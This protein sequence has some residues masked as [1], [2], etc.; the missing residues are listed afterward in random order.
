[1]RNLFKYHLL[2]GD[3]EIMAD[4]IKTGIS[5]FDDLIK[6]GLV[7][8]SINLVTGGPGSGK[9][10]FS[11]AYLYAGASKFQEKG[12]YIT[13]DENVDDLR[14]DAAEF[15]WDFGDLEKKG[16]IRFVYIHPYESEINQRI[17]SEVM[18]FS[19]QRIVV[20]SI[21]TLSMSFADA[22]EVRK[23]L[24]KLAFFFKKAAATTFLTSEMLSEKDVFSRYG[25]EE[26]VSDSV[27]SFHYGGFGGPGDR[28]VRI[29]KMRRSDHE[30][31]PIPFK[32]T[33]KGIS[34]SKEASKIKL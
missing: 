27:F 20:D 16:L 19:P 13:F 4:R 9:S 18:T 15:G 7:I 31:G 22:Y 26:F 5:G 14:K 24:Y 3:C 1:M 29:I 12:L 21:S 6:G 23:E 30:D 17:E 34:F 11:L 8:N 25:V 33:K 28:T 2:K 32:I 10:I